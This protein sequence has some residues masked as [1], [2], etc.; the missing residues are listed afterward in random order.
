MVKTIYLA[1]GCFWGTE[2]LMAQVPGVVDATSG[3]ANGTTQHPTY[4]QVVKGNTGHRETVRVTYD[5]ALMDAEALIRL[6]YQ[7]IDPTVPNRQGNDVGTQYRSAAYWTTPA[8]RDA[9][10]ATR[11]I[12]AGRLAEAGYGA[13]TTE[14]RPAGEAGPFYYAEPYHQQ[15]LVKNPDGYCPVHA[16][17]VR[18]R[19]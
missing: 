16:T 12:F 10:A 2:H 18:C 3:Y 15:Y 11:A 13:I 7:T 4:Q 9:A 8:Q 1:G 19:A 14:I 5:P 17:G 6:F